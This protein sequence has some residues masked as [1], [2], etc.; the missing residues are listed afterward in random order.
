M[1]QTVFGR[2]MMMNRVRTSLLMQPVR[3]FHVIASASQDIVDQE[4]PVLVYDCKEFNGKL[5][6][7]LR[8]SSMKKHS[9]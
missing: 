6:I 1:Q 8:E 4:K 2:M 9:F 5:T 7:G 3:R